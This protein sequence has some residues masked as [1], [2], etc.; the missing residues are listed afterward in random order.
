MKKI[1][2]AIFLFFYSYSCFCQEEVL[3]RD[4]SVN[5]SILW[6]KSY[7]YVQNNKPQKLTSV[8]NLLGKLLGNHKTPLYMKLLGQTESKDS[9]MAYLT[10]TITSLIV[11]DIM[12]NIKS[13]RKKSIKQLYEEI[14]TIQHHLK[15]LDF[16][17][18]KYLNLATKL[19]FHGNKSAC[20]KE[21]NK[22]P[23]LN[24]YMLCTH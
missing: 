24:L 12:V 23:N 2:T 22:I 5:Y 13:P 1:A 20:E 10:M 16:N 19:L 21:L 4:Y 8:K 15:K 17:L 11:H 14:I 9:T 7:G 6:E 18:Y 3:L